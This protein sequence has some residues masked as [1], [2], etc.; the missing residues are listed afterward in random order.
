MPLIP[1]LSPASSAHP[2]CSSLITGRFCWKASLLF[3]LFISST[4]LAFVKLFSNFSHLNE[5]S[6]VSLV[7]FL[8]KVLQLCLSNCEKIHSHLE[9]NRMPSLQCESYNV[10]SA[11]LVFTQVYK[12]TFL[13]PAQV[14]LFHAERDSFYRGQ[15]MTGSSHNQSTWQSYNSTATLLKDTWW[16][17]QEETHSDYQSL[18]EFPQ[19]LEWTE[20]CMRDTTQDIFG[21]VKWKTSFNFVTF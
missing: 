20:M 17:T 21:G 10:P 16:L 18:K 2:Y 6:P 7:L 15:A 11:Y 5:V 14:F 3:E 13:P 12:S 9:L 1:I 4:S 19:S 8:L